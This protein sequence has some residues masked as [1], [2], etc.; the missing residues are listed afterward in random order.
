MEVVGVGQ[1]KGGEGR[2]FSKIYTLFFFPLFLFLFCPVFLSFSFLFF[3]FFLTEEGEEEREKAS[4]NFFLLVF[5]VT[6]R[7]NEI[8]TGFKEAR[9]CL[10]VTLS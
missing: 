9:I 3:F 4:D 8:M 5:C 2:D 10:L 1:G 6:D 7:L